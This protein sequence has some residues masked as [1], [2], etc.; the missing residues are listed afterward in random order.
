[1]NGASITKDMSMEFEYELIDKEDTMQNENKSLEQDCVDQISELMYKLDISCSKVEQCAFDSI[2]VTDQVMNG[3]QKLLELVQ[4]IMSQQT[5]VFNAM[6]ISSLT[7][8]GKEG[9][10]LIH[11]AREEAAS[12]SILELE[13]HKVTAAAMEANDA[14]RCIEAGVAEQSEN[15]AE[16]IECNERLL[17][18]IDHH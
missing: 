14:A 5:Q 2:N 10:N 15:I 6:E 16:L 12:L 3:M 7:L 17:S 9:E 13:L 11:L 8:E 1:M 4:T 18:E